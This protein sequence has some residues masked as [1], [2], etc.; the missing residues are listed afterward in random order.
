MDLNMLRTSILPAIRQL[1]GNEPFCFQQDGAPP[2]YHRDVGSYLDETLLAQW[3]GRR[4]SVEY[5]PRSP[6]L[7]TLDF[8]LWG[9]L[10][11]VAYRRK[12][13]TLETLREEIE[14]SSGTIP[15]DTLATVARPLVR[16]NQKC[17][18]ANDGHFE[19]LF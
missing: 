14:K 2:H 7:T 5:P 8:Y 4:G 12:S 11:G 6:D 3:I 19:H 13:P 1:W 15:V 10:K 17:L 9:S 16:R 18:Q